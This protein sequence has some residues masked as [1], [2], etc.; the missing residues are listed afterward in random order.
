MNPRRRPH[1]LSR[2]SP[3]SKEA[4]GGGGHTPATGTAN[5]LPTLPGTIEHWKCNQ[6][7]VR[8]AQGKNLP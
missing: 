5:M 1:G 7:E 2:P 4:W 6:C 8:C 3:P